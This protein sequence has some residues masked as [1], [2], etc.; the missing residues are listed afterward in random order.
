MK[1]CDYILNNTANG[2]MYM[3]NSVVK[4]YSSDNLYDVS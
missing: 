3:L 2:V 1:T 4:R